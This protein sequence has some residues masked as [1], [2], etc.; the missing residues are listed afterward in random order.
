MED[1]GLME[2]YPKDEKEVGPWPL[3]IEG[4]E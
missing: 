2:S 3:G 1:N 4:R